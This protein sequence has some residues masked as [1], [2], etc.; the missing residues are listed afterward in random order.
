MLL[1]GFQHQT[2]IFHHQINAE[3]GGAV[4]GDHRRAQFVE[5]PRGGGPAEQHFTHLWQI[6][7]PGTRQRQC[8][9]NRLNVD[10][11]DQLVAQLH[12]LPGTGPT[13]MI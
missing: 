7:V 1:R 9:A 12:G 2:Q 4:T 10:A 3:T 13:H 8:L 6:D 11:A 5:H